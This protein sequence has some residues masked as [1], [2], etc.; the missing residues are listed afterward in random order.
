MKKEFT[1]MVKAIET[2]KKYTPQEVKKISELFLY[3]NDIEGLID[4]YKY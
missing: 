1:Q 4:E 2:T 3:L